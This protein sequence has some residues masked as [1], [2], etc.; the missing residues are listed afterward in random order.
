V[1]CPSWSAGGAVGGGVGDWGAERWGGT[2]AVPAHAGLHGL[3][4]R[5]LGGGVRLS[6]VLSPLL[7]S[8]VRSSFLRDR[9]GR[10]AH[11]RLH[12][13]ATAR[14]ADRIRTVHKLAMIYLGRIRVLNKQKKTL[15]VTF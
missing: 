5:V 9:P 7:I 13:A 2:S 11:G 10:R 3:R 15:F 8:L 12:R 14:T 4:G 6:F 1:R